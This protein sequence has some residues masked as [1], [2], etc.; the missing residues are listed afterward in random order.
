[1]DVLS[2]RRKWIFA[3]LLAALPIGAAGCSALSTISWVI[4]GDQEHPAEFPG[5]DGKRVA[6]VC[7]SDA[8]SYASPG[9]P[10]VIL[11]STITEILRLKLDDENTEIVRQDQIADWM[12]HND[13]NSIDYREIGAGVKADMVVAIE[14]RSYSLHVDKTLYKGRASYDVKVYD[15]AH[16]G[17]VVWKTTGEY[18]FPRDTAVPVTETN[19]STFAKQFAFRLATHISRYF[20]PYPMAEDFAPDRAVLGS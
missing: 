13:W 1:M 7:I 14:L 10:P 18:S 5:L 2:S 8:T 11:A 16:S 9:S 15:T 20:Y 4:Y 17:H 12:D 19:E 3:S 6:V